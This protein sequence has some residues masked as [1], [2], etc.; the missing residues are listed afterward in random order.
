VELLSYQYINY[1]ISRTPPSSPVNLV[2]HAVQS[3]FTGYSMPNTSLY[4]K[5]VLPV[6]LT[7]KYHEY[8]FDWMPNRV[9]FY[10]DG[11]WFWD[12]TDDVPSVHSAVFLKHWSNGAIGWSQ[13]PPVED[14]VMTTSYFKAYFNST[15]PKRNTDYQRRCKDPSAAGAI[16]IIPDQKVAPDPSVVSP[17]ASGDSAN[18][19]AG[20]W[21]FTQQYN[22]TGNQTVYTGKSNAGIVRSP[23]ADLLFWVNGVVMLLVCGFWLGS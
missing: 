7:D 6:S 18:G 19:S 10:F 22:Q 15:D 2:F 14:A 9:S 13:G 20:T 4:G 8:R 3:I 23:V 21:F 12:L 17:G 1:T 11:Q 5:P 16:C